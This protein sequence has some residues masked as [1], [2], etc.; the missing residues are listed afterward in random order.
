MKTLPAFARAGFFTKENAPG[1]R[2]ID[3]LARITRPLFPRRRAFKNQAS[4]ARHV[5]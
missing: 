5:H 2:R 4:L 1:A 3:R